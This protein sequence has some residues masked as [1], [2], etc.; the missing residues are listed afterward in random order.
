MRKILVT[1][2]EGGYEKEIDFDVYMNFFYTI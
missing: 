2:K 1:A